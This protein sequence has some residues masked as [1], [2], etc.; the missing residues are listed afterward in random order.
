[1][2]SPLGMRGS[3]HDL[4][5]V[6]RMGFRTLGSTGGEGKGG[7]VGD[8]DTGTV[9]QAV[10][11]RLLRP[12][13]TGTPLLATLLRPALSEGAAAAVGSDPQTVRRTGHLDFAP[14]RLLRHL[15]TL[16]PVWYSQGMW[17]SPGSKLYVWQG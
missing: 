5:S 6:P 1:M 13:S 4:E 12:S 3:R 9:A 17:L 16:D 14:T 2:H 10:R 11:K 15:T 8:R 7:K